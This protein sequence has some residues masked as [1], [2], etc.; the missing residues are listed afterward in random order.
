MTPEVSVIIAAYNTEAYIARAIESVLGQTEKNLEVIVVDDASTDATAAVARGF[1]DRRIK[2]FV[3]QQNLGASSARN[4]ALRK[5]KGKWIAL[6]DSDDWY[7]PKR[8][9]NL[10]QVA[11]TKDADLIA[12]DVFYI[13]NGAKFPWTTLIRES[14]KQIDTIKLID[15]I[16][17]VDNDRPGQRSLLL[18]LTK[19]MF[20]RDFLM[21]HGID[22]DEN[23]EIVE[24]FWFYL[25][26]LAHGARFLLVPEPYY[27]YRS[28]QG[29]VVSG[30]K[31]EL[32][33]QSVK[34]SRYFLQQEFIQKNPE[35]L[36]SVSQRLNLIE[37]T[38]AYFRVVDPLKQGHW[39]AA[40]NEMVSNPYFF[41]HFIRQIPRILANRIRYYSRAM[42][43]VS[44]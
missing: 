20:K 19:P 10:L 33:E 13:Q 29:S 21:N 40:L 37:I 12:D 38:R 15:P 24:D 43:C 8:L 1:S 35:L 41:V 4:L 22:Y 31:I 5:A 32:I 14:G 17:F 2:V 23:I 9:E 39:L 28:R 3:H 16:Y 25:Q 26:C 18:G 27:F 6:L 42:S 36:S 34:A 11:Y 7:A 30:G 44:L